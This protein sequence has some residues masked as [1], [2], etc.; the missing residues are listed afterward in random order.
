MYDFEFFYENSRYLKIIKGEFVKIENF[1]LVI[2]FFDFLNND[3]LGL[4]MNVLKF[5]GIQPNI[6]SIF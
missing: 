3:N 5:L 2:I 4:K 6:M 1:P